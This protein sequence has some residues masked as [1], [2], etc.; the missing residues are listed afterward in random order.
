MIYIVCLYDMIG[1]AI[2]GYMSGSA[3]TIGLGQWPKMFGLTGVDTHQPPYLVF[4]QFFQQLPTTHIDAAFG[5]TGLVILY[6][7]KFGTGHLAALVPRLKKPLFF[8]GI[9]RNG[10]IVILGT[11]LSFILNIGKSTSPFKI[12]KEVPA[13]FDA[14]GIPH[15]RLDI[16]TESMG[17]LPSIILILVLEHVRHIG[18]LCM[19]SKAGK[20]TFC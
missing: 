19:A 18:Y 14:M 13:G 10:L 5:V 8:M 2:A 17:V 9:M 6:V 4:V 15:L 7:I 16:I 12:I 3:I 20:L 1:P 11:F